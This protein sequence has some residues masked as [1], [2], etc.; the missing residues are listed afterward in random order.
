MGGRV[1]RRAGGPAPDAGDP[2]I[3]AHRHS[4]T[5]IAVDDELV[6][7]ASEDRTLC[8]FD[9]SAEGR[10]WRHWVSRSLQIRRPHAAG[11]ADQDPVAPPRRR[12]VSC[13][14]DG[15][16][17]RC[18]QE[19]FPREGHGH[20]ITCVHIDGESKLV[21]SGSMDKTVKAWD[22]YTA[23]CV[24]TY[25][26][27]GDWVSGIH[28][29]RDQV[30]M[31]SEDGCIRV[32]KAH[33]HMVST[34]DS[35]AEIAELT[36][37]GTAIKRLLALDRDHLLSGDA[38]GHVAYWHLS[39]GTSKD[40]CLQA[41]APTKVGIVTCMA[42]PFHAHQVGQW[43]TRRAPL[44]LTPTTRALTFHKPLHLSAG[45]AP[46]ATV[47]ALVGGH[48]GVEMWELAPATAGMSGRGSFMVRRF[49]GHEGPISCLS[50]L[51]GTLFTGSEDKTVR[52][53]ALDTGACLQIYQ[54]HFSAVRCM[55]VL[56]YLDVARRQDDSDAAATTKPTSRSA[57]I[58]GGILC[59]AACDL[60]VWDLDSGDVLEVMA[61]R[62]CDALGMVGPLLLAAFQGAVRSFSCLPAR[63]PTTLTGLK[64]SPVLL[65]HVAATK[66]EPGTKARERSDASVQH[67]PAA[68]EIPPHT[69]EALLDK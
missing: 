24:R 63:P 39:L 16:M 5:A 67:K 6:V 68:Q 18:P 8:L 20:W 47:T 26:Q 59:T 4:V 22:M 54:G 32:C 69:L 1:S 44:R 37:N 55:Q 41:T 48:L 10:H 58:A 19:S 52:A 9:L 12:T 33:P 21:Y 46:P 38:A 56:S 7:T 36:G 11:S 57:P 35:A 51:D 17:V 61:Q 30:W 28:V 40:A 50:V 49:G 29:R 13:L 3:P 23:R 62:R 42:A 31:S 66:Q 60:R 15:A 65:P 34:D 14:R 64:P 43:K 27:G 2:L 25:C 45:A 53:W